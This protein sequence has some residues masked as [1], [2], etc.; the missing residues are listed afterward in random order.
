MTDDPMDQPVHITDPM[1][2][3]RNRAL[4]L[5]VHHAYGRTAEEAEVIREA[6]HDRADDGPLGLILALAD[7]SCGNAQALAPEDWAQQL[8][9]LA[10]AEDAV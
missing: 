9:L 7:I 10:V 2:K 6:F 1:A 5:L 3:A 8:E 4:R